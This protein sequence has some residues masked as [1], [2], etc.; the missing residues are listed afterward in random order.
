MT[1]NVQPLPAG[2]TCLS[3][4]QFDQGHNFA[5]LAST[6]MVT[7]TGSRASYRSIDLPTRTPVSVTAFD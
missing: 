5:T 7:S 2:V 3:V 4:W 6:V 1:E